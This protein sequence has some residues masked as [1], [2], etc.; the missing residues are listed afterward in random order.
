MIRLIALAPVAA[1]AAAHPGPVTV[2]VGETSPFTLDH[3]EPVHAHKAEASTK[4]ERGEVKVTLS[5]LLGPT[6]TISNN[7]P[8]GYTFQAGLIGADPKAVTAQTCTPPA[9]NRLESWP[10]NA[11]SVRLFDFE[12]TTGG[13]C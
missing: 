13:R 9:G 7:S 2:S 10:R 1:T 12:P 3:G 6:M 11:A 4:P 5:A 8:Q